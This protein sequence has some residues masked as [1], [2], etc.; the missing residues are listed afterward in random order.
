MI[1]I[2]GKFTICQNAFTQHYSPPVQNHDLPFTPRNQEPQ[3]CK[4][5]NGQRMD[6]VKEKGNPSEYQQEVGEFIFQSFGC[7]QKEQ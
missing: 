4:Q 6:Y 3:Q 5:M 2:T 1:T 7:I